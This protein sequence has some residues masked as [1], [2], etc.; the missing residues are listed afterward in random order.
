[1][2]AFK[3][4]LLVRCDGLELAIKPQS[5]WVENTSAVAHNRTCFQWLFMYFCKGIE[6]RE[7]RWR[8]VLCIAFF[9]VDSIEATNEE[10]TGRT[11]NRF[12]MGFDE[13][14]EEICNAVNVTFGFVD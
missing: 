3:V 6:L 1:M 2:G 10:E 12:T 5:E 14:S 11:S 13:P 4:R 8:E 9:F 7:C